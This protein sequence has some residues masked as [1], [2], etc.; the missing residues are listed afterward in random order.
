LNHE[1]LFETS[2]G[3]RL[4]AP[5]PRLCAI[6]D[7]GLRRKTNEDDFFLSPQGHL[8]IV[9]DGMGGEACGEIASRLAIQAI[10]ATVLDNDGFER[11]PHEICGRL[12]AAFANAQRA[13]LAY[14]DSHP[15]SAGLGSAALAA[16]VNKQH[17]NLCYAGDVRCYVLSHRRLELVTQDHS[18]VERLVQLGLMTRE[19]ARMSPQQGRL[20]QAI[21]LSEG[22]EPTTCSRRL[23]GGEVVLVCSDGLWELVPEAE[24]AAILN[25]GGRSIR[26]RATDLVDKANGA[27]G[28]DNIT[29]VLFG[30]G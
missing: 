25:S 21:G 29:V 2:F 16:V 10:A 26:Q 4:V 18:S 6:T 20:E 13:V 8:W 1:T 23:Y 11:T 5:S 22:F 12:Q 19:Q 24:V 7:V 14:A 30:C 15:D 3:R 28:D 9:A 27:G 17:I